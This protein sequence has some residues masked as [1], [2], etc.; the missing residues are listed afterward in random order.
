MYVIAVRKYK[1][2]VYNVLYFFISPVVCFHLFSMDQAILCMFNMILHFIVVK[3]F[4][5]LFGIN[6]LGN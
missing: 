6:G 2:Y 4:A 5:L 3:T 1:V